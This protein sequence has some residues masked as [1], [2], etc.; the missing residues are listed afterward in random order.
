VAIDV[1]L[2]VATG[3]GAVGIY[4]KLVLPFTNKDPAVTLS[5]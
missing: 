4:T 2:L 3:V 5:A 1:S